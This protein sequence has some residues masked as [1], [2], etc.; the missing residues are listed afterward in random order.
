MTWLK[1]KRRIGMTTSSPTS[2]SMVS[3]MRSTMV[4]GI[5]DVVWVGV[6]VGVGVAMMWHSAKYRP[7]NFLVG[8]RS[9]LVRLKCA[10]S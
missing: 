4:A 1:V 6:V 10:L 7:C 8:V 9:D 2:A 3:R 5:G